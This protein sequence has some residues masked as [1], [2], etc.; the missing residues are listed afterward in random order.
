MHLFILLSLYLDIKQKY[1]G[2]KFVP[3]TISIEF[4]TLTKMF[5]TIHLFLRL[6]ML[7]AVYPELR[8]ALADIRQISL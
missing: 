3:C 7:S 1:T 2:Q 5:I 4:I 8:Q 6:R